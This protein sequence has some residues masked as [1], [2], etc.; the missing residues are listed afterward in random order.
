MTKLVCQEG[1]EIINKA[2]E[3]D[4]N[5]ASA[6]EPK[7]NRRERVEKQG[8][9]LG[10]AEGE[11]KERRDR[12]YR[13][14]ANAQT[15]VAVTVNLASTTSSPVHYETSDR[16][17]KNPAEGR[18]PHFSGETSRGNVEESPFSSRGA[19]LGVA[20]LLTL[21]KRRP[22]FEPSV[23]RLHFLGAPAVWS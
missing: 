9:C 13:E 19:R 16:L 3:R 21:S 20:I 7:E 12:R 17:E 22:R 5:V 8:F 4:R 11:R 18:P 23:C 6:L 1:G 10:V 2:L 14:D 15:A